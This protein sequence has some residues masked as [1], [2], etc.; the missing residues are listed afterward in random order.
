M[1]PDPMDF[2]PNF[3]KYKILPVFYNCST[4]Y[5]KAVVLCR[6]DMDKNQWRTLEPL[7]EDIKAKYHEEVE[8]PEFPVLTL[9]D[10][11]FKV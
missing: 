10:F 6:K 3:W 5:I 1:C 2:I 11:E 4:D 8:P 7:L 9:D